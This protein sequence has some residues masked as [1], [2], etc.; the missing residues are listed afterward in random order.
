MCGRFACTIDATELTDHFSK[1]SL[2]VGIPA[3]L[4]PRYNI[5]P[6]Q[7]VAVIPND[8][9][10]KM[11]MFR[12]GLIPSWA[13]DAKTGYRMI[14]ARA[15]TVGEK[16]AFRAAFKRRRCLI[17][18]DGFYEWQRTGGRKGKIPMYIKLKTDEPFA[19]AG[20][21]ELWKP[22]DGDPISSCTIITT[23]ANDLVAKI[24]DRMPVI[25]KPEGYSQWLDP[26]ERTPDKLE[27]LLAPYPASRMTAYPV[28]ELVN[29]PR[30]DTP[31]CIEP[32]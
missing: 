27:K 24:H 15:E 2:P 17:I 26:G 6:S 20:L 18:A 12:W 9:S 31:A 30:N 23:A 14:N 11:Q 1:I 10:N 5:A 22:K 8:E 21:W 4:T 7:P 13:K 29:S 3:N 25:L 28:S 16:P 19:F 32:V